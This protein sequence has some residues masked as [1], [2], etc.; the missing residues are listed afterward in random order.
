MP[1]GYNDYLSCFLL[2]SSHIHGANYLT[3]IIK[4]FGFIS[5]SKNLIAQSSATKVRSFLEIADIKTGE[6]TVVLKEGKPEV[7]VELFGGQGTLNVNSWSPDSKKFAFVSY[8][9]ISD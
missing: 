5:V 3:I 8:E 7:L 1:L 6:R 4:N 2:E 9:L